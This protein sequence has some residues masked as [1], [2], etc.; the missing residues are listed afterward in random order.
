MPDAAVAERLW[1]ID[2]LEQLPEASSYE[3]ADGIL[4]ER[5]V[6]F[7][8][9]RLNWVLDVVVGSHIRN[10]DLG[11]GA[12]SELGLQLWPDR[13]DNFRRADM[14]F[15]AK[16]RLPEALWDAGRVQIAPDLVIEVISNRDNAVDTNLK[17]A[18]YLQAGVRLIWVFYPLTR[19]IAV[20]RRDG[21]T[22][23]VRGDEPLDGEDILPG[24]SVRASAIF[25]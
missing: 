22:S 13:P 17:I 14:S 11:E 16:G 20:F 4:K 25:A 2:E 5:H 7:R 1:T 23:M 18:D 8:S 3:L 15:F 10:N 6:S 19:E 24:F 21:S 12:D 9:S